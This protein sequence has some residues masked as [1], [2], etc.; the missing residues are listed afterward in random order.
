MIE[1]QVYGKPATQGSKRAIAYR[2]KDGRH[3][4]AVIDSSGER[5][6]SWRAAVV[7]AARAAYDGE[8][9][10]GPL[11][12]EMVFTF[13]RPKSHFHQR[14][15]GPVLRDDAPTWHTSRPDAIKLARAVED[16]L[17]G[18]LWRDDAQIASSVTEKVY[19][20]GARARVAIG[21]APSSSAGC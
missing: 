15:S 11:R 13:P 18:V 10:E 6:K 7:D 5:L 21:H 12:V 4:A 19:G 14:K 1:F 2:G 3:H 20:D 8:P 9:L 17:S 16:A